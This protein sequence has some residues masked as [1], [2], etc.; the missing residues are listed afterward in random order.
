V[1]DAMLQD[2]LRRAPLERDVVQ[3][4]LS[5]RLANERV[6]ARAAEA[7]RVEFFT[8]VRGENE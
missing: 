1:F 4:L 8:V 2:P 5:E 3:P 6:G 7:T